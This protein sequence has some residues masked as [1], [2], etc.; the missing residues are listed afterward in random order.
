MS[1]FDEHGNFVCRIAVSCKMPKT[2]RT[3][4]SE[5]H[6][7]TNPYYFE[8]LLYNLAIDHGQPEIYLICHKADLL[9]RTWT[10]ETCSFG[11][12]N[13]LREDRRVG[14]VSGFLTSF[15]CR[16][17]SYNCGPCHI[18]VASF[19]YLHLSVYELWEVEMNLSTKFW[20]ACTN[21]FTSV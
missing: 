7:C 20:S 8:Y 11:P 18:V 10:L 5:E 19:Q 13:F 2:S 1:F 21:Y 15:L 9:F 3:A 4:A 16:S 6:L 17:C 12:F 14:I